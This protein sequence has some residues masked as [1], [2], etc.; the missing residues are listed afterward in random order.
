MI[1]SIVLNV[2]HSSSEFPGT[3]KD[4]WENGIDVHIQ[5]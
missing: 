5:R 1:D 4:G 3:V 2:P